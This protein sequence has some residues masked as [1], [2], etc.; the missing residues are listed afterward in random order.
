MARVPIFVDDFNDGYQDLPIRSGTG[1]VSEYGGALVVSVS[2]GTNADWYT[3][4]RNVVLPYVGLETIPDSWHKIYYE[5]TIKSWATADPNYSHLVVALAQSD[6]VLWILG[7]NNGTTF[8]SIKNWALVGGTVTITLPRKFRFVWDIKKY[9]I[10]IQC[11]M[12]VDTWA[13]LVTDQAISMAPT[14]L[15]FG[16]KNWN[17]F[18]ACTAQYDDVL[19]YAHDANVRLDDPVI[20][21]EENLEFFDQNNGSLTNWQ[22]GEFNKIDTGLTIGFDDRA[23]VDTSP[24]SSAQTEFGQARNIVDQGH[25]ETFEDFVLARLGMVPEYRPSAND[26]EGHPYFL[27]TLGSPRLRDAFIYDATYDPW[28]NPEIYGLNGYGRDGHLYVAGVQ[29]VTMAPWASE[30]AGVDR[31]SRPD[32]PLR[33]LL[34][35]SQS[36]LVIFDLDNWPTSLTVWMRFRLGNSSNFYLIGRIA[37]SLRVSRMINGT[38]LVGSIHNGTENGGLF[39]IDFKR[40]GTDFALLIRADG[41]WNGAG[42]RN[43]VHRNQTGNWVNQGTGF[44]LGGEYV[45]HLDATM[46]I[47]MASRE[48]MWIAAGSED[49]VRILEIQ[50]NQPKFDYNTVGPLVGPYNDFNAGLKFP[51][52]DSAGWLWIGWGSYIFRAIRD[53]QSGVI[54]MGKNPGSQGSRHPFVQLVHHSKKVIVRGLTQVNESIYASTNVGVYRINRFTMEAYLCYTILGGGGGGRLN[55][56]P[57]GE[58]LGGN[59]EWIQ[60]IKGFVVNRLGKSIGYL[61]VATTQVNFDPIY[62]PQNGSGAVTII[63]TYDDTLIDLRTH[64]GFSSGLTEDGAW[65][66]MPFGT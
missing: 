34:V 35:I 5:F 46:D 13:D 29:Q 33:S 8:W 32:F 16:L 51:F 10:T 49:L 28:N 57:A 27:D 24:R 59:K 36:E 60:W 17:S 48:R 1:S 25:A 23:I 56:P 21:L 12:S 7:S 14:Y 31:S 42:G 39:S 41:W 9:T 63:R 20:G 38:L 47:S 2:G 62:S 64:N 37:D 58:L 4:G 26:T 11:E 53:F 66:L 61:A 19:I 43:I 6:T 40:T 44:T 15:G 18:P 55:S 22:W 65:F 54:V 30:T 52:F 50:A 45:Y 3:F